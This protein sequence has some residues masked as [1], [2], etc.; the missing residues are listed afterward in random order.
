MGVCKADIKFYDAEGR[1]IITRSIHMPDE[2][3][4]MPI[5]VKAHWV[6]W[7]GQGPANTKYALLSSQG[8][9]RLLSDM[10][11]NP[12]DFK[13][14]KERLENSYGEIDR[15]IEEGGYSRKPANQ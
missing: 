13:A 6:R 4:W 1:W 8:E 3:D 5:A 14:Y 10:T 12:L 9:Q 15:F 2:L 11:L 7:M